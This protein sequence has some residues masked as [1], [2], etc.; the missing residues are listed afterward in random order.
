MAETEV[1]EDH[2]DV[3]FADHT[4]RVLAEDLRDAG[5]DIRRSIGDEEV[6]TKERLEQ[7]Y[8]RLVWIFDAELSFFER[9]KYLSLSHERN[10]AMNLNSYI[11]LMG[12]SYL[13]EKTPEG[14]LLVEI[15]DNEKADL[16]VKD[17]DYILTLDADS[18]LLQG[19]CARLVHVLEEPGNER[20]GVIQT[21]YSSF[22]GAPSR[23]ERLA[24]AT[25][26]I[27]HIIHQ[28]MA[29]HN[30][31]FWVGA[32]AVIRKRALEDIVESER[33]GGFEIKR[34]VQDHTV[35]ED[36]E[37]SIDLA[38]KDWRLINYPERLSYSATPPDFGSLVIQRRRWANGGLLILPKLWRLAHKRKHESR[39]LTRMEYMI[40]MNYMASIAW[41]SVGLVLL[42]AYPYDGRL[43]SPL[44]LLAA[45]PYFISMAMDLRGCRYNYSDIVRIYGFN[46]ILLPVNI[47]GTLKSLEQAL[48][49]KKIPF[50]R[51]P[52]VKDRTATSWLY[53]VSP[54]LIIGFSVFTLWR[55]I[56]GENWGNAAFAGFNAF[57]ASWAVV[58]YIGVKNIITDLGAAIK[59]ALYVEVEEDVSKSVGAGFSWRSIVTGVT[60]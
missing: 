23:L 51:T 22:R 57:A 28:G 38:L 58:A 4:L 10:K 1:Y 59:N 47:A 39:P 3:F 19:Y 12:K 35:I 53:I 13:E 27:Q 41:S 7:L 32:N 44:V 55:N 9:K 30:A 50:A 60:K 56:H 49:T 42:L 45:A 29:Y 6:Y 14:L 5:E 16:V 17:S 40:R 18:V 33:V 2:V 11:G 8:N 20:V 43:L 15:G 37:S 21:P 34:Y 54:L 48:T 46:L 26:D 24:G 31:T 25:T 52:K 36:T